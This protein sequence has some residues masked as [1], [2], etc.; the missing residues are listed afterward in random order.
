MSHG[1]S[2]TLFVVDVV[3]DIPMHSKRIGFLFDSTITAYLMMGNLGAG[4][5]THAVTMFERGKLGDE[6]LDSLLA[7]LDA[8]SPE[9]E[10]EAQR[11]VDHAVCMKNTLKFLRYLLFLFLVISCYLFILFM[12]T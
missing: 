6:S 5:K 11:Y 12:L 1:F 3:V 10:G 9:A 7:E 2:R 8:V 4:L